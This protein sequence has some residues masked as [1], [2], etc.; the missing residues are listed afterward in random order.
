MGGAGEIPETAADLEDYVEA[1]RP[2]LAVNEQTREFFEFLLSSPFGVRLP[3]P[4]AR[5]MNRF[6]IESGMSLMPRWAQR[7][8]GFEPSDLARRTLHE[9]SLWTYA[10]M[11]RW[12]FGT[13]PFRVLA[14]ERARAPAPRGEEPA[15]AAAAV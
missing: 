11:L 5:P 14:E 12:A 4:L 6:Q 9:P 8:T 3:G 15:L 1:M 13:P 2:N 10:R 7:L